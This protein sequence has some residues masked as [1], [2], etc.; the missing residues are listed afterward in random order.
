MAIEI[1]LSTDGK[2]TIHVTAETEEEM[3]KWL[4]YAR[5]LYDKIVKTLGTKAEMWEKA[6][7]K[8][9]TKGRT[10][11]TR[12]CKVHNVQMKQRISKRTGKPYFSHSRQDENGE[13]EICFGRGYPSENKEAEPDEET[14]IYPDDEPE[15]VE[16]EEAVEE[17]EIPF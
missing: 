12:L 6:M 3:N 14:Y 7:G 13:W 10:V 15:T 4:P 11:P 16:N 17:G 1:F 2:Q 8:K 5:K 9:A